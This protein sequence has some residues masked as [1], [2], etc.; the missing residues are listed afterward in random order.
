[1]PLERALRSIL[2]AVDRHA[3]LLVVENRPPA[4]STRRLV[5]E[6]FPTVAYIEEPLPGGSCA[7]NAGLAAATGDVVGFVDDDVVV[8]TQWLRT[9]IEAFVSEDVAC[10]CGRITP[11]SLDSSVAVLFDQLAGFD[12]GHERRIFRLA[13]TPATEPL[14]PTSPATSDPGRMYSSGVTSPSQQEASTQRLD[15]GRRRRV[16]RT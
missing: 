4:P 12:K 2:G 7:R 8:D 9:A 6:Q 16:A 13:E 11:L 5:E 1:V 10:V 14:F 3:E 15:P